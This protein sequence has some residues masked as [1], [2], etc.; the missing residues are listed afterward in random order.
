MQITDLKPLPKEFVG[1]FGTFGKVG[2]DLHV[3]ESFEDL[4]SEQFDAWQTML[5]GDYIMS[6]LSPDRFVIFT[7]Y[8]ATIYG[9]SRSLH[10]DR[11]GSKSLFIMGRDDLTVEDVKN[12]I[13]KYETLSKI[14]TE[15][16]VKFLG[17]DDKDT[18]YIVEKVVGGDYDQDEL[19]GIFDDFSK[20]PEEIWHVS[21]KDYSNIIQAVT[22]KAAAYR[23]TNRLGTASYLEEELS[24][25]LPYMKEHGI[26]FEIGTKEYNSIYKI[27]QHCDITYFRYCKEKLNKIF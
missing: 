18:I 23:T 27:A 12:V 19:V 13:S 15:L 16:E 6:R 2:H 1:Y 26:I 7:F 21:L 22:E 14:F 10:D 24:K 4:P 17:K 8:G 3:Y 20:V 25:I 11:P 5:D 9:I